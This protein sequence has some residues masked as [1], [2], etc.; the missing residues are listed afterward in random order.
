MRLMSGE[1]QH[2]PKNKKFCYNFITFYD[3]QYYSM[4]CVSFNQIKKKYIY[5]LC[6]F[7]VISSEQENLYYF[8]N[9]FFSSQ[10]EELQLSH[11]I[12]FILYSFILILIL[13]VLFVICFYNKYQTNQTQKN[14]HDGKDFLLLGNINM[15][16]LQE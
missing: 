4:F 8:Y 2:T 13:W 16:C 6:K 7:C 12:I 5:I 15:I 9:Q 3:F 10:L 1:G 14:I 11:H